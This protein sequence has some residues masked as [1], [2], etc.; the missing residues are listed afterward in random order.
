MPIETV[1]RIR[2][3]AIPPAW[4]QVWI[5]TDSQG[6]LQATGRDARGRKQY[7][8]HSDW[9]KKRDETKYD[10]LIGFGTVLP[11]I[12]R[13]VSRDMR[14]PGLG[15]DKVL[16]AV[17]HLLDLSGMRIGNE[18]YVAQNNSYG[19]T[20]LR[21][22]H[23][24]VNGSRIHFRFRGKSGQDQEL[25]IE[26]PLLSRIVKKCQD[27]PGQDLFQYVDEKGTSHNISSGH[28]NEYLAQISGEEFTAKDFR[29]WRGT[30]LAAQALRA[31]P[32][33]KTKQNSKREI[34]R[35]VEHVA[36]QLGNTPAVC[37][38]CYIHPGVIDSFLDGTLK[39]VFGAQPIFSSRSRHS[40]S[41]EASLLR[42]MRRI[43]RKPGNGA[44][45]R[46]KTRI[47]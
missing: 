25:D 47:R 35:A 10:R 31:S 42:L 46:A 27:L 34:V 37:R 7:R 40:I 9:R 26:H 20:T 12:R 32:R 8:Y 6:H 36:A 14:K 44:R 11:R 18:E 29:T 19:L 15:Q 17:A 22:R 28:V 30:L 21:N 38:K 16:A 4:T 13:R 23:A 33:P 5:C 41:A 45:Q 24:R 2:K 3:L 43:Q 1:K 39:T